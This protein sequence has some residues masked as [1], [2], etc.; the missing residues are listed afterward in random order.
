MSH[1]RL[2]HAFGVRGYRYISSRFECGEI[3]V[4][5]DVLRGSLRCPACGSRRVHVN[6]RFP[7]QWRSVPVGAKPVFIEMNVP[8]IEC[9]DCVVRRRVEVGFADPKR[10]HMRSFERYVIELLAF[11]TPMDVARHLGI[12]WDLANDIQKLRLQKHFAKSKLKHLRQIAIH[13]IYLVTRH[14][15][16]TLV[17]DLESGA[18]VFL[19][20]GKGADA[21]N[22]LWKR[23][24]RRFRRWRPTCPSPFRRPS[25]NI[26]PKSPW[27]S[28]AS[29]T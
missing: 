14:R 26:F 16:I 28:I 15:F 29:T 7:R 21:L 13:E 6:E 4:V 17:L 9:Q 25:V 8:K 5:I 1:S 23:L 3:V 19:G 18:V 27:C 12:S 20:Q 10:R 2:Y 22:P 11:M 24:E